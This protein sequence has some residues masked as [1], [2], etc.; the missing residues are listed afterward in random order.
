MTI[1]GS[2]TS[3]G[4]PLIGCHCE[5]CTSL[6]TR[7][8]RLRSSI[9]IESRRGKRILIDTSTDLREQLLRENVSI[10]DGCLIT[11]EHA[12]HTHGIDDLKLVSYH[13]GSPINIYT[14]P[15]CAQHL[16]EKFDYIFKTAEVYRNRPLLGSGVPNLNLNPLKDR[17]TQI[18]GEAIEWFPLPHGYT[19][20]ISL[21]H[22][23]LA[24]VIDCAS[25]PM[26]WLK[27]LKEAKLDVLLLDCVRFCPHHTHL[28]LE[29]ALE[30][31][32][33]IG[34]KFTGLTHL[35]HDFTHQQLLELLD[36]RGLHNIK[37]IYDQ[38]KLFYK[39]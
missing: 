10:I 2:G 7:D 16:T 13:K 36:E 21:I 4:I 14:H 38:Q 3:T 19:K 5:V 20:S 27:R 11:H 37:P 39:D 24:Y 23:K 8:R 15:K 29:L 18:E 32:Q 28:D 6:D 33:F 25:I 22:G 26:P 34:A 9:L 35:G 12:D 1:L 30:Y 17:K 31:A